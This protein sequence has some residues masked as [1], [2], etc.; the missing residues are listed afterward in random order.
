M[1]SFTESVN[2]HEILKLLEYE[3]FDISNPCIFFQTNDFDTNKTPGI[4]TPN[5]MDI[6][7]LFF[8]LLFVCYLHLFI[9]FKLKE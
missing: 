9:L 6:C 3:A 2:N 5:S 8:F 4:N 1:N 7:F